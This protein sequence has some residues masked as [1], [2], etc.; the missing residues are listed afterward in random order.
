MRTR[1]KVI[2]VGVVSALLLGLGVA[3]ANATPIGADNG[4]ATCWQQGNE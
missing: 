3:A 4:C 1:Y 2:V